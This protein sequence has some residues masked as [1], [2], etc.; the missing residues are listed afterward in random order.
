MNHKFETST[1]EE[2]KP[3][4]RPEWIGYRIP[5][6][7]FAKQDWFQNAIIAFVRKGVRERHKKIKVIVTTSPTPEFKNV[8]RSQDFAESST[9][10]DLR[11]E[12][13]VQLKLPIPTEHAATE[14]ST[15]VTN[16]IN[17]GNAGAFGP[18]ATAYD[19][20]QNHEL[21][22]D[23]RNLS[24]LAAKEGE[25]AIAADINSAAKAIADKQNVKAID[26]LKKIADWALPKAESLAMSTTAQIIKNAIGG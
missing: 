9:H 26:Y 8:L 16:F 12:G 3:Y 20:S 21:I 18:N 4:F 17:I 6:R 13:E 19:F 24:L 22:T 15:N 7:Y 2:V 14:G 11:F 1:P 25:S 5:V 23:L 10:L